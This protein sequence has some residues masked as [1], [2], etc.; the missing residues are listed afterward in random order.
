MSSYLEQ[1]DALLAAKHRE[2]EELEIARGVLLRLSATPKPLALK[3]ET[4]KVN[5]SITI[6][7]VD[8]PKPSHKKKRDYPADR[9]KPGVLGGLRAEKQADIMAYLAAN[10][11]AKSGA[12]LE[13]FGLSNGTKEQKQ[14]IYQAMYELKV[15]G[16]VVRDDESLIYRL[17]ERETSTAA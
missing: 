11:P 5:G 3:A 17:V 12:I 2:I 15:Q 7:K 16:K 10:G 13:S 8:A 6:R 9:A 14:Q 4:P 1:I